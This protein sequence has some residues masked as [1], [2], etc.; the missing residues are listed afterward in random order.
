MRKLKTTSTFVLALLLLATV[1]LNAGDP[2]PPNAQPAQRTF[3]A[4]LSG[5]EEVPPVETDAFGIFNART[6]ADETELTFNLITVGLEDILFAHIHIAPAG[7]NGPVTAF[8]FEADVDPVTENGHLSS[9]TIT[10][11]DLVGPLEGM[12]I[13]DLLDEIRSG[14]AYVNVHTSAHPSGEIRGQID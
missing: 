6:N 3:L 10:S 5:A 7:V 8:L 9:G 4:L 11:A 13:A 12:T 2:A 1:N 14:N